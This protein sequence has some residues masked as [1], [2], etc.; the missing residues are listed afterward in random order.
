MLPM[1]LSHPHREDGTVTPRTDYRD[2]PR[3]APG[4]DAALL[5]VADGLTDA[6]HTLLPRCTAALVAGERSGWR[7][8]A[9]NGPAEPTSGWRCAVAASERDGGRSRVG[10]GA[11]VAPFSSVALHV[12]LV[13]TPAG[14]ESLPEGAGMIVQ[15]L[16][17]AGGILL[18]QAVT[19]GNR[20]FDTARSVE[21]ELNTF[22]PHSAPSQRSLAVSCRRWLKLHGL[23]S[24]PSRRTCAP[25]K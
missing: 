14:G 1:A 10:Y 20:L 15:P 6:V 23:P 22:E 5:R 11:F 3:Y 12:L 25:G 2:E 9:Q 4:C 19:G 24:Q 18:D 7:L 17:D 8:L 16:L 13:L 21:D